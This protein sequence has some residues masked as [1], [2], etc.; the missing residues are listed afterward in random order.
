MSFD[1]QFVAKFKIVLAIAL[2]LTHT[3]CDCQVIFVKNNI[4]GRCQKH[5]ERALWPS[6]GSKLKCVFP[7]INFLREYLIFAENTE[8]RDF[9]LKITSNI[10]IL[11]LIAH[12]LIVKFWSI[13]A[14]VRCAVNLPKQCSVAALFGKLWIGCSSSPCQNDC[15]RL[16]SQ[17]HVTFT[18]RCSVHQHVRG[19]QNVQE[20]GGQLCVSAVT[21]KVAS[22]HSEGH[23]KQSGASPYLSHPFAIINITRL[24][25]KYRHFMKNK[26]SRIKL[27]ELLRG[28][29]V[30]SQ[31]V[32]LQT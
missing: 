15:Y 18:A 10:L 21:E 13:I 9:F 30:K 16:R 17:I 1:G 26:L 11:R 32:Y 19:Q 2:S 23:G 25:S 31:S 7:S 12:N 29:W 24:I 5:P 6:R 8:R 20:R 28:E 14:Y 3:S 27:F 22:L 4:W